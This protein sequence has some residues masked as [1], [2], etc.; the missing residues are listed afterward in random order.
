M[1]TP[2]PEYIDILRMARQGRKLSGRLPL[3]KM[4]RL[5]Q[6]LV[7]EANDDGA[8]G[9]ANIEAE[10]GID[11]EQV[12]FI[13][14]TA[15]ASVTMICQRCLEQMQVD[16][17]ADFLLAAVE[18]EARIERLPEQYEPLLISGKSDSLSGI[19]EDELIL[20]SP[21]VALHSTDQCTVKSPVEIMDTENGKA[22]DKEKESENLNNPFSVLASLR[23][24]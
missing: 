4:P 19:I 6:S 10:F 12:V 5:K 14:G 23:K 8:A 20:A 16:L 17:S 15:Q 13:R 9:F 3:G 1:S 21:L 2:L 24:N 22:Q 7:I 18:D 11:D